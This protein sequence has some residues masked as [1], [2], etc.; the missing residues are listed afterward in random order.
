MVADESI[1]IFF[2]PVLA[3]GTKQEL[4]EQTRNNY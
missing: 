2:F 3:K 4:E 1:N